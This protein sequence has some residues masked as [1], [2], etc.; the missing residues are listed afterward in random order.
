LVEV[1]YAQTQITADKDLPEQELPSAPTR[2]ASAP[3]RLFH[4]PFWSGSTKP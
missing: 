1:G 4:Q 3:E 2:N